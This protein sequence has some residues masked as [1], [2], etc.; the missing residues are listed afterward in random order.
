MCNLSPDPPKKPVFPS[1]LLFGKP[2]REA[3]KQ[4]ASFPSSVESA[5]RKR[6]QHFIDFQNTISMA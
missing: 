4:T 5:I 2:T 1:Q 6:N 3:D